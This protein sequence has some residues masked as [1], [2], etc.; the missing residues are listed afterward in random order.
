MSKTITKI[1]S[2]AQY[3]EFLEEKAREIRRS[4]STPVAA[5]IVGRREDQNDSADLAGQSHEEWIFLNQNA[6]NISL[7][8]QVE[9][10]L[11]RIKDGTFGT[12]AECEKP[13]SQK[14]LDAVPWAKFCISCQEKR[15]S[16][17]N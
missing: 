12:C 9:G 16:W 17:T 6:Q 7:L 8:R 11:L 10:A 4:V 14:R 15:G 3:H 2:V 13:I 1:K 5:E